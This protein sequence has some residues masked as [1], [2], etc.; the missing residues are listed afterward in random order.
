MREG[1]VLGQKEKRQRE[2]CGPGTVDSSMTGGE[3]EI[4]CVEH[5]GRCQSEATKGRGGKK[6]GTNWT[7]ELVD[8]RYCSSKGGG[9]GTKRGAGGAGE[10][11]RKY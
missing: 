11:E 10:Q 6:K 3:E 2:A 9:S 8:R 7:I 4:I 5:R 1:D